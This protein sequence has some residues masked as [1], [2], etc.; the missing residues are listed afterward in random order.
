MLESKSATPHDT[1]VITAIVKS[2]GRLWSPRRRKITIGTAMPVTIVPTMSLTP[3]TRAVSYRA[4]ATTSLVPRS[5]TRFSTRLWKSF[6]NPRT[7]VT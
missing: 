1:N 2:C 6:S 7:F 3:D 5:A 4:S